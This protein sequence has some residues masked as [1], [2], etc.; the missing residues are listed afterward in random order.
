M[1]IIYRKLTRQGIAFNR[2]QYWDNVLPNLAQ[3]GERMLLR[4]DPRDVSRLFALDEG[5][6]YWPIPYAD[7]KLPAI[8]LAEAKAAMA[9]LSRRE[10]IR[11]RGREIVEHALQQR[12]LVGQATKAT[13]RARRDYQRTV[14]AARHLGRERGTEGRGKAT[15]PEP[16]FDRPPPDYGVEI[17]EPY[18]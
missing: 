3:L 6:R 17:W 9:G 5:G 10:G 7:L 4:Y 8:T 15:S 16:D 2:I 18:E 11:D 12:E 1:P 13:K 14:E